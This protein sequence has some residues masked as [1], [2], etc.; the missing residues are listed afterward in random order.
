MKKGEMAMSN[1]YLGREEAPF[2]A[3]LWEVLDRAM[4]ETAKAVLNGR[5]L[6]H[7]A[8]PYGL[9]LKALALADPA[10]DSETVTSSV[11]PLSL[12][13]TCFTLAKRDVAAFERDRAFLD[14]MPVADATVQCARLEDELVFRGPG[15][16][17]GLLTVEG[18]SEIGLST[19]EKVGTAAEDIIKAVTTLDQAGFHGPYS[20]ALAPER[21]NLLLRR[22]PNDSASE[23]EH[24]KT[25]ATEGVYKAPVL[26]G[27]GV[28]L[29]PLRE[30][31]CIVVGQDMSVGFTGPAAERLEFTVSETVA[32][33]IRQPRAICLLTG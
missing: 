16:E 4:T 19:W 23:L 10:T 21:Y 27:G 9:G 11:L 20:L 7:V 13:Q 3:D 32:P 14:A 33:L 2:G 28:L 5:R 30:F 25:M 29:M 26:E 31:A 15:K 18:G 1:K 12:I 17:G 24:V 6:V 8:G 22:Y